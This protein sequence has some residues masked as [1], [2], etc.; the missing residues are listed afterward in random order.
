MA[1]MPPHIWLNMGPLGARAVLKVTPQETYRYFK[2]DFTA[3]SRLHLEVS[4]GTQHLASIMNAFDFNVRF[5][6][7]QIPCHIGH[8]EYADGLPLADF[9]SEPGNRTARNLAQITVDLFSLMQELST[10][11]KYHNDLHDKNIIVQTL[12]R[13]TLRSGEAIAPNVRAVAI[14]LGSLAEM[15]RSVSSDDRLGDLLQVARYILTF[16]N[17]LLDMPN[18]IGDMEYRL[19]IQLDQIGHTLAP[20]PLSQREPPYAELI[21][22]IQEGYGR[23]SSPWKAPS[24]L[25]SFSESYNAQ[26]LHPSFVR[27]LLVDPDGEWLPMVSGKGPQVIT[28]IRGCGKTML[29]K[30]LQSHSQISHHVERSADVDEAIANIRQEG[31]LG[32]YVP[33]NRL[34][35]TL[36]S[37]RKPV[38]EPYARLFVAYAL[39]ALAA[40]RHLSEVRP[41]LLFPGHWHHI[42]KAIASYLKGSSGLERHADR[43]S[44]RS[45]T[46]LNSSIA[47]QR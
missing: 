46:L 12:D 15:S 9:L 35:D 20:D 29:L 18:D 11:Q 21:R 40:A 32:L 2:K 39:E 23:S 19:A 24:E 31:Y 43:H 13:T 4:Q 27:R 14:D 44:P 17:Y 22:R 37:S 28:G 36:G 26:T 5:G 42:G 3:E 38:H 16:R 25:T 8:L 33:T 10:R 34:L 7:I 1:S 45:E 30:A 41:C 6:D 47:R